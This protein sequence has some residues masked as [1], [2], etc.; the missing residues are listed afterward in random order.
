MTGFEQLGRWIFI[1]LASVM[2]LMAGQ[3][4]LGQLK[5]GISLGPGLFGAL[6]TAMYFA[7]AVGVFL[8]KPWSYILGLFV[9]LLTLLVSAKAVFKK[10]PVAAGLLYT[11]LWLVCLAWFLLPSVMHR[12]GP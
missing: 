12:F 3:F 1:I 8:W 4:F 7:A 6:G 5:K 11:G 10:A 2:G 9:I